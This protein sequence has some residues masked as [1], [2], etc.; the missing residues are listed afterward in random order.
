MFH[1]VLTFFEE[2]SIK[3]INTPMDVVFYVV[4]TWTFNISANEFYLF[5]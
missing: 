1:K 5:G 2:V 3:M 4:A